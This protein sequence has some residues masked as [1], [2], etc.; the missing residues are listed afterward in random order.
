MRPQAR[1]L[2]PKTISFLLYF[3]HATR[4]SARD[5]LINRN[6]T[7]FAA[8]PAVFLRPGP[9]AE[10]AGLRLVR[11]GRGAHFQGEDVRKTRIQ[12]RGHE[13]KET[14][15]RPVH[16]SPMKKSEKRTLFRVID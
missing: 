1:R 14:K 12:G 7:V 10:K 13:K 11:A 4:G 3:T 15:R 8:K 6:A 2:C 16:V 5:P 9:A